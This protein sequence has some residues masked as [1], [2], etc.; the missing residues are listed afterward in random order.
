VETARIFIVKAR[1]KEERTVFAPLDVFCL[2][3]SYIMATLQKKMLVLGTKKVMGEADAIKMMALH[4]SDV[5]DDTWNLSREYYYDWSKN[6]F[7]RKANLWKNAET[8]LESAIEEA[9]EDIFKLEV[10]M[11]K[12]D[13]LVLHYDTNDATE[14]AIMWLLRP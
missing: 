11:R 12:I 7:P 14:S 2:A 8:F 1:W 5:P 13:E 10:S 6:H 4:G 9:N 3:Q